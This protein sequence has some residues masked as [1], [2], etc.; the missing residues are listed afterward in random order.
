VSFADFLDKGEID[1]KNIYG[2]GRDIEFR[3]NIAHAREGFFR[4]F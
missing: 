3:Q 2:G 1:W 4:D